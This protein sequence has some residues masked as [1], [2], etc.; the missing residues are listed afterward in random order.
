LSSDLS[1]AQ[2]QMLVAMILKFKD[3]FAWTFTYMSRIHLRVISHKL[4]IFRET[5]PMAQKTGQLVE[6]RWKGGCGQSKESVGSRVYLGGQVHHLALQRGA[7][8]ETKL[9]LMD[10]HW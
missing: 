9:L 1:H 6:E 10:M 2:E 7:R 4:A 5:W 3:L 8:K